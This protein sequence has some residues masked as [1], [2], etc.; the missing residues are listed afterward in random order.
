MTA[1]LQ[2]DT[3]AGSVGTKQ[4]P[5]RLVGRIGI[6]GVLDLLTAVLAGDTC[7]GGDAI[8]GLVGAVEGL[9]Q[10]ALQPQAGIFPLREDDQAAM[11]PSARGV[12]HMLADP[13][14]QPVDARVG[15]ALVTLGD[16][17][18]GFY[19]GDGFI[20]IGDVGD[21]AGRR[22]IRDLIFLAVQGLQL[23]LF[24]GAIVIFEVA[25]QA[26]D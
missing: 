10:P 22:R 4:Y 7:K 15:P 3:F 23:G 6:K 1:R 2:V 14:D 13:A 17:E 12:D 20:K 8:L 5:Q 11:V 9:M 25:L 26:N 19:K 18:H 16:V 24:G 21:Y